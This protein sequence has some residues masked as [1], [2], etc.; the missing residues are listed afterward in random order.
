MQDNDKPKAF[1]RRFSGLLA[2]TTMIAALLLII[3]PAAAEN[4][5]N[6]QTEDTR[7]T[8]Q[9]ENAKLSGSA[10]AANASAC[11]GSKK[12]TGIGKDGAVLFEQIPVEQS[13]IYAIDVAYCSKEG[14]DFGITVDGTQK[15]RLTCPVGY[16]ADVPNRH[17]LTCELEVGTH[18]LHFEGESGEAP[19]LDEIRVY[20]CQVYDMGGYTFL[21]DTQ[22]GRYGL[23]AGGRTRICDAYAS[24]KV[25]ETLY[26]SVDYTRRGITVEPLDDGF[27]KGQVLHIVSSRDGWPTLEQKFCLYEGLSYFLTDSN[28]YWESGETVGTNYIAPLTVDSVG[29]AENEMG[30]KDSFLRVPYDND[31]W[32]KFELKSV[33]GSDTG[34]EAAAILDEE[35]KK[36]LVMGSLS[37]DV[38]KT[39]ITFKGSQNQINELALY[40]GA[41]GTLTRDQSP[42]GTVTGKQVSSPLMFVGFYE[43]WQNGMDEFAKANTVVTPPKTD[44]GS[45]PFGWNSWGSVQTDLNLNTANKIS[46]YIAENLQPGWQQSEDDVVYVVLDSY[47][48]NLSDSQLKTFVNHCKKNGQEAGIYWAPFVSWHSKESLAGSTVEGSDGVKYQDIILKKADGSYYGNDLD[49]AFPVDM[50]HPAAQARVDYFIDRFKAAGFTYIKLDFL[51]HGALEGQRYDPSVQTGT[52]AYNYGMK[53]VTDRLDGQMFVTCLIQ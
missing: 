25:G 32:V 8:F 42:H 2:T 48:D 9:A 49:G 15:L 34:Y 39:G 46:D 51:V 6:G 24:V 50:T 38:W 11:A 37:H 53:Y 17:I 31:G 23:L 36:A 16:S 21:L 12:V 13:G 20:P 1:S 3:S 40:G 52:Q 29:G 7:M 45:V 26:R 4:T 30:G 22:T 14:G 28:I 5:E 47:W 10:S 41:N 44:G 19:D 18:S 43:D 33:N 27:G 35:S